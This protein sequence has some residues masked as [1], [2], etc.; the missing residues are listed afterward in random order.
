MRKHGL[1]EGK[2]QVQGHT[3][4]KQQS[5]DP[6]PSVSDPTMVSSARTQCEGR[7]EI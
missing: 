5:G 7:E 4:G 6:S 1:R 3:V 2:G